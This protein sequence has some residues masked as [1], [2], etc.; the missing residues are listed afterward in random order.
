[1]AK[2]NYIWHRNAVHAETDSVGDVTARYSREPDRFGSLISEDRTGN[3]STHHYDALGSTTEVTDS[4]ET[5]TDTFRYSGQKS[6]GKA[7]P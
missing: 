1:M 5:V 6:S 2:T 3:V 7:R 4:T